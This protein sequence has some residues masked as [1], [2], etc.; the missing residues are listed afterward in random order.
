MPIRFAHVNLIAE[1]WRK[2]AT[3]YQ[4]VFG[5]EPVPPERDQSGDWLDSATG[6]RDAHIRGMHLRL[7]GGGPTLEVYQ[8]DSVPE[9][10]EIRPNT[11]GFSH[12][13]FR[14]DDVQSV[15]NDVLSNGGGKVG[16]IEQVN[17]AGVGVLQFQ[18][19]ADP[20]GNIIEIQHLS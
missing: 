10:P 18:Y 6:L 14:V 3:F 20:E 19:V 4:K 13:A 12:I 11:P 1:D 9:R 17:I 2:L 5:C 8:Y 7:P 15:A 16:E